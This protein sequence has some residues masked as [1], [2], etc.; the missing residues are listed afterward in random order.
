MAIE[1]GG[2]VGC[3]VEGVELSGGC[4]VRHC[5][6]ESMQATEKKKWGSGGLCHHVDGS[7]DR[8]SFGGLFWRWWWWLAV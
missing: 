2:M 5:N 7:R 4:R 1:S 8:G 3:Q 6:Q